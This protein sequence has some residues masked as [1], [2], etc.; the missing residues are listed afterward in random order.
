MCAVRD[1]SPEEQI[2]PLPFLDLLRN[3]F[4]GDYWV[5]RVLRATV[6]ALY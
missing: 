1:N 5:L 2:I 6:K 3:A 4:P